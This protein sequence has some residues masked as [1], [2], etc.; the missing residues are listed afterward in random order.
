MN[1][2]DNLNYLK[3]LLYLNGESFGTD[4][5]VSIGPTY[6]E[7]VCGPKVDHFNIVEKNFKKTVELYMKTHK[8]TNS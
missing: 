1:H 4:C 3:T 5:Y 7:F 2:H 6:I 8:I